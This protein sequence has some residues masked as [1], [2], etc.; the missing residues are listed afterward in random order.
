MN[1][2]GQNPKDINIKDE[3]GLTPLI[4][5]VDR[6]HVPVCRLLLESGADPTIPDIDGVTPLEYA[7]TCEHVE[8]IELLQKTI[9]SDM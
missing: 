9:S 8:I 1:L 4:W 5:A 7:E 2:F 3:N 6:G